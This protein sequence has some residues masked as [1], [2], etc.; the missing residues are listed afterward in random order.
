MAKEEVSKEI[1]EKA[2]CVCPFCEN[3][4]EMPAPWCSVC[5]VEIR[6]CPTCE[7]PLPR[8]ATLCPSC[9]TECGE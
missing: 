4:L 1:Q 6:F 7:E 5:E 8:D 3:V 2:R 9:G